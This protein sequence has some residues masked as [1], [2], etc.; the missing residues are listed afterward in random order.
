MVRHG[1]KAALQDKIEQP[2]GIV[3]VVID[4]VLT[5]EAVCET[6]VTLLQRLM[7]LGTDLINLIL[8]Q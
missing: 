4:L 3:H 8:N 1:Y 7:A 2:E 6:A 5:S